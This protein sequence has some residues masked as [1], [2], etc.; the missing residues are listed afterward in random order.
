MENNVIDEKGYRANVA[1]IIANRAGKVF[2]AKRFGQESWQ[3]PQGGVNPGESI[4]SAMYRELYEEVGL[5]PWDVELVACTPDW[6][7]YELPTHMIR[8]HGPLCIGQKQRWFLLRLKAPDARI[9]LHSG[10]S[11]EFDDWQW[12]DPQLTLKKV[13]FFKHKSYL[14]AIR[15]FG[16]F[17]R[18]RRHSRRAPTSSHER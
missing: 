11:A 2:W 17:L 8:K 5:R 15:Y 18:P 12:A 16:R 9:N 3:F 14:H 13:I 6:I 4:V 10:G 1:M 7:R